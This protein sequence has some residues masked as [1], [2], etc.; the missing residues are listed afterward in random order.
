MCNPR[1]T[2][3]NLLLTVFKG[4]ERLWLAR[5]FDSDQK[6]NGPEAVA[7]FLGLRVS[8]VFPISYD[9]SS[10]VQAPLDIA[11]GQIPAEPVEKLSLK[12]RMDLHKYDRAPSSDSL[13]K[14]KE[15]LKSFEIQ[16]DE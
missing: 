11:K 5:H 8:D 10:L 12:E 3:Q 9:I 15:K 13:K 14:I 6:S 4:S 1:S 7:K 2:Q 16:K